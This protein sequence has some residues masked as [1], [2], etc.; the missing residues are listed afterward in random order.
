MIVGGGYGI[1]LNF[2][3]SFLD[4]TVFFFFGGGDVGCVWLYDSYW[5]VS[6][7]LSL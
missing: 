5:T 3:G 1:M 7:G 2:G 6:C 4:L